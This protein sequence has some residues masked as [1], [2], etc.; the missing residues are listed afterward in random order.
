MI[1]ASTA[2]PLL[3]LQTLEINMAGGEEVDLGAL[4]S[5]I[6]G[7]KPLADREPTANEDL[8]IRNI[9]GMLFGAP[10]SSAEAEA[11]EGEAG[12]GPLLSAP[13][14][15]LG[16]DPT[17]GEETGVHSP[18]LDRDIASYDER[19]APLK[20][21]EL[22]DRQPLP[23]G[24]EE[25][26]P[27]APS[28]EKVD[29]TKP[30]IAPGLSSDYAGIVPSPAVQGGHD[31]VR[32]PLDGAPPETEPHGATPAPTIETTAVISPPF[33]PSIPAEPAQARPLGG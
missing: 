7:L 31:V 18:A 10:A 33:D 9:I 30:G 27:N 28:G 16:T 25:I 15:P 11:P 12:A 32:G 17:K 21:N 3:A 8:A 29:P 1:R 24:I 5:L 4:Q 23:D 22:H 13:V 19:N 6:A 2:L 14:E 26:A 20:N